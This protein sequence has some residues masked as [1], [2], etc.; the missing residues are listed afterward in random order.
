MENDIREISIED[1]NFPS[2]LKRIKNPPKKLFYRGRILKE[3]RAFAVVGT[4]RHSLYGKQVTI[5]ITSALAREGLTIVSGLA[6]GID[7]LSHKTALEENSR[8]IAVLG[9]GIDDKS[10]YPRNNVYLAREIVKK[11]GALISEYPPGTRGTKFT[12]PQ[13]N[14]IIAGLSIGVLVV[15]A[16]EKSGALITAHFA[17]EQGKPVFAIPG[18]INSPL[19]K[20]CNKLIQEGAFLVRQPEDILAKLGISIKKEKKKLIGKN[21]E[22][23][24]ILTLLKDGPLYIDEI[25][26]GTGI[27]PQ[28]IIIILSQME[29]EGK[30]R[31]LGQN[32]FSLK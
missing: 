16:P 14:R 21:E 17:K 26:E 31:N 13:R 29:L 4:R 20:G 32:I 11:G 6:P 19:S 5:E 15:E 1:E 10:I 22:E 2:L 30:I 8:T 23:N 7:T 9:T 18:N 24:K 27:S 12:F 28:K 3:E 25:I